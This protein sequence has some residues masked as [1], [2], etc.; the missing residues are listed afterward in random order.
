MSSQ[1]KYLAGKFKLR[2]SF[3]K[4][5]VHYISCSFSMFPKYFILK[6]FKNI[7]SLPQTFS[8]SQLVYL[9]LSLSLSPIKKYDQFNV[10]FKFYIVNNIPYKYRYSVLEAQT[11][12]NRVCGECE[13]LKGDEG[14]NESVCLDTGI[15]LINLLYLIRN[16]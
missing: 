15:H 11:D 1:Q 16:L 12:V 10:Q 8:L 13:Q 5:K 2:A 7:L 14:D 6:M 3:S 4:V 9:S